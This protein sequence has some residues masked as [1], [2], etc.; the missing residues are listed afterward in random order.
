[1]IRF[2]G[3]FVSAAFNPRKGASFSPLAQCDVSHFPV[4]WTDLVPYMEWA[5]DELIDTGI[6]AHKMYVDKPSE[7]LRLPTIPDFDPVPVDNPRPIL[8]NPEWWP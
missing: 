3:R 1:M 4:K 5:G 7:S 8:S 6:R 2:Q